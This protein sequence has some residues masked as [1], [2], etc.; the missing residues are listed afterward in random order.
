MYHAR[1]DNS[2]QVHLWAANIKGQYKYTRI[3]IQIVLQ[4]SFLQQPLYEI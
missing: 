2:I 1:V 4:S 3:I